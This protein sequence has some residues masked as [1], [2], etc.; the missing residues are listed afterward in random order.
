[1]PNVLTFTEQFDNAAWSN[2]STTVTAD[3]FAAPGFTGTKANR[4]DTVQDATGAAVSSLTQDV[5]SSVVNSL[6]YTGS[7]YVRKDAVTSRFPA[8]QMSFLGAT[9]VDAFVALNTSTGVVSDI[10]GLGAADAKGVVD[11]DSLWWRIWW[12]KANNATGNTLARMVVYPALSGTLGQSFDSSIL[13]S[14]VAWG[15]QIEQASAVGTYVPSPFYSLPRL[16]LFRV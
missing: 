11:V 16:V 2:A 15:A 1:M 13:G 3:T 8:F 4:A 9:G 12:R 7:I 5:G 6:D 14:I 10:V